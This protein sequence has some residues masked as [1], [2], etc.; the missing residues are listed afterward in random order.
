MILS[1]FL[2]I[3]ICF[4][5]SLIATIISI[6][7]LKKGGGSFN[8]IVLGSLVIRFFVLSIIL[9]LIL[10]YGNLHYIAFP[11]SFLISCFT[12]IIIEILYLN[13]KTKLLNSQK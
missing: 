2:A 3:L 9:F 6:R 8:K 10:H 7:A 4:L 13:K 11:V 12:F 1:I 5:N